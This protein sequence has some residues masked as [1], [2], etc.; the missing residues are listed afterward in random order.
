MRIG[1]LTF[2]WNNR[3]QVLRYSRE[4]RGHVVGVTYEAEVSTVSP[5][6]RARA[7]DT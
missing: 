4:G 7:N 6:R 2:G 3:F 5:R 1:Y